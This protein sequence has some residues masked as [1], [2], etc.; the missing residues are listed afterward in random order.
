[1][2]IHVARPLVY[3]GVAIMV[4]QVALVA[5]GK[6]SDAH[7]PSR[8]LGRGIHC[9]FEAGCIGDIVEGLKG[10]G[11]GGEGGQRQ[12][13]STCKKERREHR[14][15]VLPVNQSCLPSHIRPQWHHRH[16]RLVQ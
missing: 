6:G 8:G 13:L 16:W 2:D 4:V 12:L 7:C 1:M 10:L 3:A 11:R 9:A 5:I 15:I 14:G